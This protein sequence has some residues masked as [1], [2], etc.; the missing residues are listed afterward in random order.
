MHLES[1]FTNLLIY[2]LEKYTVVE[3]DDIITLI[4]SRHPAYLNEQKNK[5]FPPYSELTSSQPDGGHK[6]FLQLARE[7]NFVGD[8]MVNKWREDL[9][10]IKAQLESGVTWHLVGLG[11]VVKQGNQ[12]R[13]ESQIL[14]EWPAMEIHPIEPDGQGT[15][16]E[17]ADDLM[18][19]P[20]MKGFKIQEENNSHWS[21]YLLPLTI[22][23]L[24][25]I[26]MV[27]FFK[28][29]ANDLLVR[30]QSSSEAPIASRAE[31]DIDPFTRKGEEYIF[32]NELLNKYK[33]ILTQEMLDE[34]CI[35]V[36]GSFETRA[37]G[38]ALFDDLKTQG[39]NVS[40]E[41]NRNGYRVMIHFD[42]SKRDI[43]DYLMEIKIKVTEQA[44][45]FRPRYDPFE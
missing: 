6:T 32:A 2:L 3:I 13:I 43:V 33:D 4:L 30:P 8:E 38:D 34:G 39:Y 35:I 1:H 15:G 27:F 36:V 45:L 21:G 26:G 41:A 18:E 20:L 23:L 11:E 14:F 42:C 12:I 17:Q 28:Y 7:E 9:K 22:L 19:R 40:V 16:E 25:M 29:C 44:W 31:D 37:N 10:E 24:G 5:L